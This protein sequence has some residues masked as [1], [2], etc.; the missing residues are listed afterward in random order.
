MVY[1]H[2]QGVA[3]LSYMKLDL[4]YGVPNAALNTILFR[5]F[6]PHLAKKKIFSHLP[7]KISI[8]PTFMIFEKIGIN[9]K[10]AVP[11]LYIY[12]INV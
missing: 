8:F 6:S 10:C 3:L 2:I 11:K 5:A 12:K 1:Y 4:S 9:V 7:N